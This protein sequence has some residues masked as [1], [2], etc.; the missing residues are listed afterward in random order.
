MKHKS[1]QYRLKPTEQQKQ[2][3]VQWASATRWLWNHFLAQNKKKY[4][5]ERKFI[6]KHEQI[7]QLPKLKK[8]LEWLKSV[9]SQALQQKCFDL[10][11]AIKNCYKRGA[12]F[13]K[14]KSKK[15]QSDSFRIPQSNSP[16]A[17]GRHIK[18]TQSHITIPKL[19]DVKWIKHRP[20]DGR[21]KSVTIKQK[22]EHWFASVL[23]EFEDS[24]PIQEI[25]EDCVI[26]LDWGLKSFITTSDGETYET[27][28]VYQRNQKK[29]KKRNRALARCKLGS[30]RR[31]QARIRVQKLHRK[32]AN[33]RKDQL[34]KISTKIAN[35]GDV[36]GIEDLN[37]KGMAKNKHLS[38]SIFDSGW[39][40][41]Q[42]LLG[43]KLADNGG[44]LIKI[45]RFYTS[46]KTCSVCG[47]TKPM[48]LDMKTYNCF[49]C[50]TSIDRDVNAAV[51]IRREAIKKLNRAGTARIQARG[52]A[53]HGVESYDSYDS[54]SDASVKREKFLSTWALEAKG[55]LDPW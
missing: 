5:N 15:W 38:K 9:P 25:S 24:K 6:F 47:E 21:V 22:G 19:G 2:T 26:G 39:G 40:M 30:K 46:S 29:L 1:Y 53:S 42:T 33:I 16:K 10:D 14:F 18:I 23:C 54:T 36:V 48:P 41:F 44:Q 17:S 52:D 45:D 43:Y 55:F 4:E 50:G 20:I 51:N 13:P 37:I 27:D 28:P 34:H 32:I 49:S 35:C 12:G 3:F 7:L 11:T 31:N 8:E